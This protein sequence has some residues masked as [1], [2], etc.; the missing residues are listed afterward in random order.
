VFSVEVD[1]VNKSI[2]YTLKSSNQKF[3][4][5]KQKDIDFVCSKELEC[6]DKTCRLIFSNYYEKYLEANK[7]NK[8][9][10]LD[11]KEVSDLNNKK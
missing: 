3:G 11:L 2:S 4:E 5:D 1:K 10:E 7:N 8:T 6:Y 9:L